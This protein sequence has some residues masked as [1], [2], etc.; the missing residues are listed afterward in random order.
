MR[1]TGSTAPRSRGTSQIARPVGPARESFER[2]SQWFHCGYKARDSAGPRPLSQL[3]WQSPRC[4]SV[5]RLAGGEMT[6]D[7]GAGELLAQQAG[8]V[9]QRAAWP[10]TRHDVL[11]LPG[12]VTGDQNDTADGLT[13]DFG[14]VV[15]E[16][17]VVAVGA[18]EPELLVLIQRADGEHDR[19]DGFPA[20]H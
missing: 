9:D 8:K 10:V 2:P 7:R 6:G 3:S 15:L 20:L 14:D 19:P 1:S 12:G 16:E 4:R 17:A 11:G 13:V 18:G 5:S